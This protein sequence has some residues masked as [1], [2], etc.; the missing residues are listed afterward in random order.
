LR[1]VGLSRRVLKI[2][3]CPLCYRQRDNARNSKP[4]VKIGILNP[5]VQ[6]ACRVFFVSLR[7][8]FCD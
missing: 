4:L 7:Y 1:R 5:A 3:H 8:G 2:I 6:L